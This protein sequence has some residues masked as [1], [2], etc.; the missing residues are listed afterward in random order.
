MVSSSREV[1]FPPVPFSPGKGLAAPADEI[2]RT[3]SGLANAPDHY[4]NDLR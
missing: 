1:R 2:A 3:A 4:G